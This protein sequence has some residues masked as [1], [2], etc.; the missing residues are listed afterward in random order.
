MH[1][2][3]HISHSRRK[4]KQANVNFWKPTTRSI[5]SAASCPKIAGVTHPLDGCISSPVLFKVEPYQWRHSTVSPYSPRI[6]CPYLRVPKPIGVPC[7]SVE[8]QHLLSMIQKKTNYKLQ[9]PCR[10]VD[11]DTL[12]LNSCCTTSVEPVSLQ[13]FTRNSI[14]ATRWCTST[15]WVTVITFSEARVYWGSRAVKE[16]EK[17]QVQK[18]RVN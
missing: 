2:K 6:V 5:V 15:A 17:V 4:E 7:K 13:T 14:W 18:F 8:P 12:L 1:W 11:H 3:Y 10:V 16:E 9:G